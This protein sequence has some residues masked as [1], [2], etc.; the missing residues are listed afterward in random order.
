MGRG[1]AIGRD[2]RSEGER[3][4]KWRENEGR[5]REKGETGNRRVRRGE[6][7]CIPDSIA[8]SVGEKATTAAQRI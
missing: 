8:K 3:E 7:N 6:I 5:E 2:G 1:R 4:A